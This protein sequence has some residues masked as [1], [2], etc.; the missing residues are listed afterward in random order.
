MY[1]SAFASTDAYEIRGTPD[2][3]IY[4]LNL[5]TNVLTTVY[6]GYPGG[7]SATLAQRPSDGMLFYAIN[8]S[9]GQVY[10]FNPATPNIAPVAL[11]ST[12]GGSVPASL[13][14]GFSAGGTL[15]Y[16]PDTGVLY[17]IN[18]V[19][20]VA[21]A[22]PTI[23]GMGSG[24]DMAFNAG[25]T[26]YVVNSSRQIFTAPLGGGA[27]TLLGTLTFPAGATP[28]VIGV[29]FDG[30]GV[31]RVETQNPSSLYTVNLATLACS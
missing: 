29:M 2:L 23:T 5:T 19:T 24:G 16:L 18:Q 8:A 11:T 9:D 13:R 10:R 21:T 15:Y 25:G 1:Q 7:S 20:G 26:L 31:M 14:M 30:S 3:N 12:L 27:A 6:A 17:T 28:A 22:G 4:Q